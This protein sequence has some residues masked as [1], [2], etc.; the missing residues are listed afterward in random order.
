ML[1]HLGAAWQTN[2][3]TTRRFHRPP[4]SCSSS[5]SRFHRPPGFAITSCTEKLGL[6]PPYSTMPKK[7][8][9]EAAEKQYGHELQLDKWYKVLHERSAA[10]TTRR[11]LI[12]GGRGGR[13]T[14]ASSDVA[15]CP[16]LKHCFK[17]AKNPLE[18]GALDAHK[19][20][21][22]ARLDC[23]SA[24]PGLAAEKSKLAEVVADGVR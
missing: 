1:H 7:R 13:L 15:A 9:M 22:G 14:S 20:A 11:P 12:P 5:R 24:R 4:G 18:L 10:A 21:L 2:A 17:A 3:Q 6:S 16:L 23:R 19:P 8:P